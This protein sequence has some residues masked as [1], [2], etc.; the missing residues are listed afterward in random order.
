[1]CDMYKKVTSRLYKV[2]NFYLIDRL[3]LEI[4][5]K[6]LYIDYTRNWKRFQNYIGSIGETPWKH[7][8]KI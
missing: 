6:V 8:T 3:G 4:F 1:M 5:R 7:K 2:Q